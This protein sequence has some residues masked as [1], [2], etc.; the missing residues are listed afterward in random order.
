MNAKLGVKQHVLRDT[1]GEGR[2]QKIV[3]DS[4]VPTGLIQVLKERARYMY[5]A[6]INKKRDFFPS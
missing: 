2:V 5:R 1:V 4:G 6:E 3:T